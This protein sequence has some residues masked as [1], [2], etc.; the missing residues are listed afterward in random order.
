[1]G[2]SK[3]SDVTKGYGLGEDDSLVKVIVDGDTRKILGASVVG[4]DA[5]DLV[6]QLVYLMNTDDQTYFP[7][8]RA[9][10]IHPALSEAVVRAFGNMRPVGEHVHKHVHQH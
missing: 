2:R 10:V 8:A 3:Y 9:Q 1:M 6:Q 5:S 7:I 4:T